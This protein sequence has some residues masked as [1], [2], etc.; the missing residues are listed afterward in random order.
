MNSQEKFIS[1]F[2]FEKKINLK[3]EIGYWAGTIFRWYKEGLEKEPRSKKITGFGKEIDKLI[4]PN[5]HLDDMNFGD[6]VLAEATVFD[7]YD[8]SCFM[9]NEIHDLFEGCQ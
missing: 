8:F 6:G 2:N 7:D 9:E 1:I 5:S 4:Y 3:W